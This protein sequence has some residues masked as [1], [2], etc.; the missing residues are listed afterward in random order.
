MKPSRQSHDTAN[1]QPRHGHNTA[2]TIGQEPITT[3]PRHRV[4]NFRIPPHLNDPK[5]HN[6]PSYIV[7]TLQRHRKYTAT[8]IP[9]HHKSKSRNSHKTTTNSFRE[10]QETSTK[11]P[12]NSYDAPTNSP[13]HCYNNPNKIT[14][15]T[16]RLRNDNFITPLKNHTTPPRNY[17][18]YTTTPRFPHDNATT[19]PQHCYNNPL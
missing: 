9:R 17:N 12:R 13:R 5:I 1:P 3:P 10:R 18:I 4:N 8:T 15:K 14:T 11:F 16:P 19:P 2:T 6:K 7:S